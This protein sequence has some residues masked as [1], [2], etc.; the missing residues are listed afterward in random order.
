MK[1]IVFEFDD[2]CTK[3]QLEEVI[4]QKGFERTALYNKCNNIKI[5]VD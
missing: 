5:K 3:E 4:N 2:R 1:A